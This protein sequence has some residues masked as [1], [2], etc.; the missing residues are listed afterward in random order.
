MFTIADF[1]PWWWFGFALLIG[2]LIGLERE[3]Y[4]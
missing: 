1:E 3:Y 2:A 4:Q